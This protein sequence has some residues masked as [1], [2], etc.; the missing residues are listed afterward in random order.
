M[1]GRNEKEA[2]I[3]AKFDSLRQE[4]QDFAAKIT[5]LNAE[6]TEHKYFFLFE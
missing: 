1:A 2:E 4:Q 3:I 5:E 6:E